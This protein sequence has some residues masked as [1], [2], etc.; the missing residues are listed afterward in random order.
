M[1]SKARREIA[2]V[3]NIFLSAVRLF[4]EAG[5]VNMISPGL[6]AGGCGVGDEALF[7]VIRSVAQGDSLTR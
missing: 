5:S 3:Q 7:R 6:A 1:A 4:L 2:V